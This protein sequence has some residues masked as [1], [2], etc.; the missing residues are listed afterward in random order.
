MASSILLGKRL[1]RQIKE[2]AWPVLREAGF[3]EFGSS[4]RLPGRWQE[5]R[6]RG[7]L[8]LLARSGA[9]RAGSAAR[10]TRTGATFTLLVGNVLPR[11]RTSRPGPVATTATVAP[12]L[13]MRRSTVPPMDAPSG[14][15]KKA[16]VSTPPST[17]RSACP[18]QSRSRSP[19]EAHQGGSLLD[20]AVRG[21]RA[22]PRGGRGDDA[23]LPAR[24]CRAQRRPRRRPPPHPP[25]RRDP[26]RVA[27]STPRPCTARRASGSTLGPERESARCRRPVA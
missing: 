25:C 27:P 22:Q 18:A 11:R 16:N 5:S 13:P 14:P 10:R 21:D 8:D 15:A 4:A 17:R 7:V 3:V 9:N 19:L 12:A 2:K 1:R 26:R 23:D 6:R 20:R 24:P